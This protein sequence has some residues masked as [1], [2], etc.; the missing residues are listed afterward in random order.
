[1][2]LTAQW[3]EEF[4]ALPALDQQMVVL[5]TADLLHAEGLSQV[6][7][8]SAQLV[9]RDPGQAKQLT[10]ICLTIAQSANIPG[11]I[12]RAQYL[13]AQT[14]A[15]TGELDIA[16]QLIQAAQAGYTA[17]GQELLALSTNVGLMHILAESGQY[18]AAIAAGQ[19]LL[20]HAGENPP[21]ELKTTVAY[22]YQNSGLCQRRL[23][24]YEAALQAY[25]TAE[26]HYRQ[27]G[28]PDR[29][30]DVCNNRGV[31][32][33]ELGR[34][35]DALAALET[36]LSLRMAA[37]QPF[38]QAQTLNNLGSVHLL[39]GHYNRSLERFEQARQVFAS[40]EASLDQHIL[41]LDTAHAYLM[42]NLYPEAASAYREAEQ[43]LAAAGAVHHRALALWGLG[44][45]LLAQGNFAEAQ[46][47]L[48]AAVSLLT[49]TPLLVT[50]LLELSAVQAAQNQ[51]E[52]ALATA[53]QALQL[54]T[55][56]Q[57]A[58]PTL[59]THLR[60]A[61][62]HLA[63][64]TQA[65]SHLLAAQ[66]IVE[67]LNL[68]QLRYRWAQ[69]FGRL[70]R[71]QEQTAEAQQWLEAA[72]ADIEHLRNTLPQ[73][74]LRTS[75]LQDKT[76]AYDELVQLFLAQGNLPKAF[77]ITE[78]ARS[79]TLVDLMNG[80]VTAQITAQN[81]V[82]QQLQQLQADLNALYNELLDGDSEGQRKIRF[83]D[84]QARAIQLEQEIGRLQLQ[85][86]A[87]GLTLDPLIAESPT[88][89]QLPAHVT[90]LSYYQLGGEVMAFVH[91][92]GHL[93]VFRHLCRVADLRSLIGRLNAQWSRFRVGEAFVTQ[94][95]P[96]LERAAQRILGT[97]YRLL[98]APLVNVL[99]ENEKVTILPHGLL[100]HIPF[101]AL[102]DGQTYLLDRF[103]ITYAPSA[104]VFA[105]CQSRS[106]F[107]TGK[108]LIMGVADETIP[109]VAREL[110][111]VSHHYP[112]AT[113]Y[114][115][116]Q[117]TLS[118]L[119][120]GV[121][122]C[123]LLHLAC[124]GLFRA[125]NPMYSALKL[126]DGWLTAV[127]TIQLNLSNALVTLS[128]CETGLHQVVNGDELL[129]LTRAFIG[130]GA[131]TI[132]VSLWLAQDETTTALMSHL[133]HHLH[134][135]HL[136]PAAALRLAQQALKTLHPHPYYWA[137]FILVG[138]R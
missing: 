85:A 74:T 14:H 126:S 131:A 27:L 65:E 22:V 73:E 86:I 32:L 19:Q 23:G 125:D 105:L 90:L 15:L 96:T 34:G 68:P 109:A 72:I 88:Y 12:P 35:S 16:L 63:D 124:H 91:Q 10:A 79:R 100:H 114:L 82:L 62:L 52:L 7:E 103:E 67:S 24:Q 59:Y 83:V 42:L 11:V 93:Y 37:D 122:G 26:S 21:S 61:D 64:L 1:M 104:T 102:F 9:R 75:F 106:M 137:P 20:D 127:Q 97:L 4:L 77:A 40:Q 80:V 45:T 17:K 76:A 123:S 13:K 71:Y 28:M 8:F 110:T 58:V 31:L 57:W 113:V 94:H 25:G 66:P 136:S 89:P 41:L 49:P 107:Q 135:Q 111:A 92:Q 53:E 43:Q 130:A 48:E 138:Q 95:L 6:V 18:A 81:Q 128:A 56:H 47:M 129:G 99:A 2:N 120:A 5:Q 29:A 55:S 36:A 39:L 112:D 108:T 134:Q 54:A 116:E 78:Q 38:L 50:I 117:A 51:P 44:A 30:G 84:V 70:R 46:Q 3:I 69:R 115:N 119:Q 121:A 132:I 133:Y 101:H 98:V 33:L 87:S 118:A 60:L